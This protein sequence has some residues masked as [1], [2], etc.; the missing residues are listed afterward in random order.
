MDRH[1][2]PSNPRIR[3][4]TNLLPEPVDDRYLALI[5][6]FAEGQL[7]VEAYLDRC[8]DCFHSAVMSDEFS[9]LRT[10]AA[11]RGGQFELLRRH[12]DNK[13]YTV[14]FYNVEQNE[15]HAPH[16][17]HNL[18]ST[19]ILVSG[20]LHL[21]EYD[22]AGR[23]NKGR[24]LAKPVSDRLMLPGDTFQASEWKNNIHWFQ[25][26]DG[27][28]LVFNTNARGFEK[29]TFESN[30]EQF[31]R[32]Y[33]DPTSPAVDGLIVCE[34]FGAEEAAK[35]FSNRALESFPQQDFQNVHGVSRFSFR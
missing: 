10:K 2:Q 4:K 18:A 14:L 3:T 33:I 8:I 28:A 12:L 20:K 15:V 23:D 31:G 17:H 6:K 25:A 32:R 35:R 34:E 16:S 22:R 19:Q 30:G 26:V 27:P 21:R 29:P 24:L 9:E 11:A 1:D 7:S 5:R 13:R